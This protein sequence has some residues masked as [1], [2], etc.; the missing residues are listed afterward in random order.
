MA[1]FGNI[2]IFVYHTHV[3][4]SVG[5]PTKKVGLKFFCRQNYIMSMGGTRNHK[6]KVDFRTISFQ[7]RQKNKCNQTNN[8]GKD[9]VFLKQRR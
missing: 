7:Q 3:F 2:F 4:I 5:I 9:I 8:N 1:F 6:L